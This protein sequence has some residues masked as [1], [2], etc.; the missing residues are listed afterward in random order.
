MTQAALRKL[1]FDMRDT[2]EKMEV[3]GERLK[4][5]EGYDPTWALKGRE[6]VGASYLLTMW[7]SSLDQLIE[8][9]K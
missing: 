2:Q 6:M 9:R 8:D 3:L 7:M 4:K 1:Y 5:L